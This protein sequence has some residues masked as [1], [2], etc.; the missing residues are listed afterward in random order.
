MNDEDDVLSTTQLHDEQLRLMKVAG[1]NLKLEVRLW[2]TE[3]L[4]RK[5]INEHNL[6][7]DE[8]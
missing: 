3:T 7:N 4:Q 1:E 5:Q 6:Y 8:D 2:Q